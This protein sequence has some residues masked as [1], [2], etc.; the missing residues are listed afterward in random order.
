M[1]NKE[2]TVLWLIIAGM[3]QHD[4]FIVASHI[5][6]DSGALFEHIG[7]EMIG[8]QL[9]DAM[10]DPIS[11]GLDQRKTRFCLPDLLLDTPPSE[12]TAI[13][14]HGVVTKINHC[15]QSKKWTDD[16]TGAMANFSYGCHGAH[17]IISGFQRQ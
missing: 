3:T 17:G 6:H 1:Q 7:I 4:H 13:A 11:L 12:Q 14:L 15:G 8:P 10:V 9:L 2:L 16:I 5:E